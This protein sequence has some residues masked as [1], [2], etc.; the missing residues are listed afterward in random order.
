MLGSLA[1]RFSQELVALGIQVEKEVIADLCRSRQA[2]RGTRPGAQEPRE[3]GGQDCPRSRKGPLFDDVHPRWWHAS[4][5]HRPR[6]RR[7][8]PRPGGLGDSQQGTG[9]VLALRCLVLR[10]VSPRRTYGLDGVER[11]V[12]PRDRTDL[13]DGLHRREHEDVADQFVG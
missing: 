7:L 1:W 6:T 5:R 13:V 11:E 12:V 2:G 3:P 9:V 4:E 8:R 10:A